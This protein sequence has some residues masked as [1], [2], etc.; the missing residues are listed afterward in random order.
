MIPIFESLNF[1]IF[2][3]IK[4]MY[5]IFSKNIWYT[6]CIKNACLEKGFKNSTE[7]V[8]YTLYNRENI[9]SSILKSILFDYDNI[10]IFKISI[11]SYYSP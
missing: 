3:K 7:N 2:L 11:V 1:W 8:G 5:T 6:P 9:V 4:W 10:P